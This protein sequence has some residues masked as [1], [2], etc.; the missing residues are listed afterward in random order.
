MLYVIP[1]RGFRKI[2][3]RKDAKDAKK[4]KSMSLAEPTERAEK[5]KHYL[6]LK[7]KKLLNFVSFVLFVVK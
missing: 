7:N 4:N 1:A 3:N 2:L 5:E 6:F